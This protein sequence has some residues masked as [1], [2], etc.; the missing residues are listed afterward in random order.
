MSAEC[1]VDMMEVFVSLGALYESS[2]EGVHHCVALYV[3]HIYVRTIQ[4]NCN[5]VYSILQLLHIYHIRRI[6]VFHTPGG[7]FLLNFYWIKIYFFIVSHGNTTHP[8][9]SALFI[10]YY[11]PIQLHREFSLARKIKYS[12]HSTL[13]ICQL[14]LQDWIIALLINNVSVGQN[15]HNE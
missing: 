8:V 11:R 3:V 13:E 9:S 7:R 6:Q 5:T 2:E 10:K 1:R 14:A 4:C 15:C 12:L